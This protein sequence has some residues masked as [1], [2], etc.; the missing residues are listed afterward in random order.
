MGF[1]TIRAT[2]LAMKLK[3]QVASLTTLTIQAIELAT[4]LQRSSLMLSSAIIISLILPLQ[5]SYKNPRFELFIV[6]ATIDAAVIAGI[7]S[8]RSAKKYALEAQKPDYLMTEAHLASEP[9][10]WRR[11]YF[12]KFF[13]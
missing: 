8:S 12:R 11:L 4:R 13:S 10:S 3:P 9:V 7:P 5:I 1:M 2:G 6:Q